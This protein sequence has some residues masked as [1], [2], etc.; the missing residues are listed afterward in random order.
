MSSVT[1]ITWKEPQEMA[2]NYNRRAWLEMGEG[3]Y[4]GRGREDKRRRRRR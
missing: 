3:I 2:D 1:A 4:K